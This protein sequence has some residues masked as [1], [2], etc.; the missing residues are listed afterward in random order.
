MEEETFKLADRSNQAT[1]LTTN[2]FNPLNNDQD[3]QL[4][5]F[6]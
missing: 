5:A 4:T 3:F 6:S 2:G 1:K